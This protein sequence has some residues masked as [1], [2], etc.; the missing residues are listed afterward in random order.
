[1]PCAVEARWPPRLSPLQ[2][3]AGLASAPACAKYDQKLGPTGQLTNKHRLAT[4]ILT[5]NYPADPSNHINHEKLTTREK[6]GLTLL[7]GRSRCGRVPGEPISRSQG[8]VHGSVRIARLH[9][10]L[11]IGDCELGL[12]LS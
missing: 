8:T 11:E 3:V 1:M 7:F 2:H 12:L 6:S 10:L 4:K 9:R 5:T